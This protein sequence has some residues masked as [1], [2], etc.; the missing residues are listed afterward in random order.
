M[1]SH[2]AEVFWYE[3]RRNVRRRGYL[4]TTF[5]IP[6]LVLVLLLGYQFFNARSLSSGS[7]ST[8]TSSQSQPD[9]GSLKKAGYVDQSGLF[10]NPGKLS[11]ILTA[12][13]DE[14]AAQAAIASG[15]IDLYYLI[16]ADY[17]KTGDVVVV[18]PRLNVAQVITGPIRTLIVNQ[19]SQGVKPDIFQ[20]LVNPANYEKTNLSLVS[21]Q[22]GSQQNEGSSFIVVY[23]FA[24]TLM[25]SLFATNGYLM[26]SVIEE[27]ETR[28]IEILIST[29]RP[30]Q[31][32][33]GKIIA[34]GLLGLVQI[35][36]WIG[37]IY[38]IVRLVGGSTLD[39]AAS[40][41]A[42]IANIK[43]PLGIFPLLLIFF[44]LA[45]FLFAGL[46]S[47]VGALSN[48]LREGPQYA[49]IFT[50]PAALPLY[51]IA[52]FTTTPN[53]TLPVIMS[54]FPLTAPLAMTQRLVIASVP[55]WQI[56]L[57]M[58]LLLL[59]GIGVMWLAGRLFRVQ[60]LLAGQLPKLK[61][62][63]RLIRG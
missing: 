42:V 40:A 10:T 47:I 26:Q 27:K 57:S 33:A 32:L 50:L 7:S 16:P 56:G 2:T 20:R 37:G 54:L 51:F 58:L 44:V 13:P 53:A 15:Q 30:V 29:V 62:L 46:Y 43:L 5:G 61:D 35:A 23:V 21:A 8:D 3:L 1:R 25:L 48:S 45:Y 39:S 17:L 36:T 63:P 38:L 24:I 55:A 6:L 49:V 14:A 28:L 11:S 34:M 41:L 4:I 60:V 9:F 12:Y 22:D 52:V 59:S 19:L 31:L 18:Q